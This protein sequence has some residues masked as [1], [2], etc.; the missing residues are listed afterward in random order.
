MSP[1]AT[2]GGLTRLADL[3]SECQWPVPECAL[4]P[5]LPPLLPDLERVC[6]QGLV[7]GLTPCGLSPR[8]GGLLLSWGAGLLTRATQREVF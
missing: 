3:C 1:K 6:I 5:A 2:L 7:T 8:P 4:G